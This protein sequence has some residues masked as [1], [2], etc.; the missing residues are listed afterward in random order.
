[1]KTIKMTDDWDFEMENKRIQMIEWPQKAAQDIKMIVKTVKG[2]NIFYPEMGINWLPIIHFPSERNVHKA[3]LQAV[4]YYVKPVSIH[5][6][7]VTT[8]TDKG[9][10]T[11]H[12]KMEIKVES[13]YETIE[14][15][16]GG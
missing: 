1:M 16:I 2:E 8:K 12:V 7:K 9:R 3:I 11:I 5:K 14:F 15:D 6:L 13:D 10:E 4:S